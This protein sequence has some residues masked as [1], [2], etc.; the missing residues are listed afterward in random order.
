MPTTIEL[1]PSGTAH[2]LLDD[3]GRGWIENTHVR[4]DQVVADVIGP[5]QMTPERIVEEYPHAGLTL[6]KIHAAMSWYYDHKAEMD[7]QFARELAM[8]EEARAKQQNSPL[9]LRALAFKA[10]RDAANG[11]APS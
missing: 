7:E 9:R 5:E 10:A 3:R 2:I 8:V 6:A 4:V 11:Q 1:R